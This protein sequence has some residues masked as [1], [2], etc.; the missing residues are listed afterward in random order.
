[1]EG[2]AG[3]APG[4]PATPDSSIEHFPLDPAV[5]LPR[6]VPVNTF[7]DDP[8]TT[9]EP[10][11]RFVADLAEDTSVPDRAR[12]HLT[13]WVSLWRRA[14]GPE[15]PEATRAFFEELGRRPNIESWQFRQALEAV[16]RF[17]RDPA[18]PS[19]TRDFAWQALADQ[20]V[21]LGGKHRTLLRET[22]SVR[23]VCP[24]DQGAAGEHPSDGCDTT[25]P[26]PG[27][28]PQSRQPMPGEAE[29]IAAITDSLRQ[30]IRK[31]NLAVA[32]EQTYV[33]WIVRFSR[34]RL[35]R[36]L[37]PDIDRFDPT[38]ATAYLEYLALER[39]VS[40]ATQKQALNAMIYLARSV[41]GVE[42]VHLGFTPAREGSR[43][44]PVVLTKAEVRAVFD[45]LEDPWKLLCELIYGAGL[46][47]MEAL[48]LRVKDLDFGQGT[49]TVHDGK[50]GKHRVV[51]L[52]RALEARLTAHLAVVRDRHRRDLEAG[53]GEVHL[54]EALRRKYP[55][56]SKEW[57]WQYIFP[58]AALCAHPRT[59]RVA[60]HHLHENSLQRQI[61]AAVRA[62]GIPKK[63]S[64]H[65]L[66]HSFATHLLEGGIDI[67][68]V[69]SLLGHAD[70]STTMI[71]LHVM[72]RPGAGAPSPL[73]LP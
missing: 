6:S 15:S 39:R 63:A 7:L 72:K 17:C 48:R 53:A 24:P 26:S 9:D 70:V 2:V 10:W 36:L 61:K 66:R 60:R 22:V 50:G 13:R 20:A 40:P 38:A 28:P 27:A 57:A 64:C 47:Q 42:D 56:A 43:R 49:I 62:A 69:Q 73:D 30:A 8:E 35:R 31:E 4:D 11:N 5:P 59:G 58:A 16:R 14:A 32:T 41:H 54:P 1:M 12:P 55:D 33:A 34:F 52:P 18:A 44:P 25:V 45:P 71:Y 3:S 51:P 23:P 21:D 46:R 65:T 68:T 29:K 37:A 67:R 19:W